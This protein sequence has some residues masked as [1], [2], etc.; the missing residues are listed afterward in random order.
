MLACWVTSVVSDSATLWTVA[1][2]APLYMGFS[3][4][5]YWSGLPFPPPGESSQ[6]RDRTQVPYLYPFLYFS[7]LPFIII[8]HITHFTY[9][10]SC[11]L[12]SIRTR[13]LCMK[14]GIVVLF[15]P[16]I[17]PNGK[18]FINYFLTQEIFA[19]CLYFN[20]KPTYICFISILLFIF[21]T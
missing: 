18:V 3:R 6:T 16:L 8:W 11:S 12:P 7:F 21:S 4:Q 15:F 14:E 5:E 10:P 20:P 17:N 2:Q 9:P 19:S 13:S 1:P